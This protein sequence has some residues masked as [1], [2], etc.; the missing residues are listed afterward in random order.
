[1]TLNLL[2]LG[3]ASGGRRQEVVRRAMPGLRPDVV[4]L[5]EVTRGPDLDAAAHLLGP[6][7]RVVDLPG[8]APGHVGE[9]PA[10]RRALG[11]VT[12]LD[13]AIASGDPGGPRDYVLVRSGAYGPALDVAASRL[14]FE[15]PEEDVWASDHVGL[16]AD[17]RRPDHAPG[18]WA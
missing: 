12:A 2:T 14:V 8:Q 15:H 18:A 6:A 3:Q 9:C 5:Q 10:S 11:E 4:A 1:M 17:L 13:V 16:V 7:Y